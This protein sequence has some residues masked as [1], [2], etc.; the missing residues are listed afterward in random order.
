[1]KILY[2]QT[3][4]SV[5]INVIFNSQVSMK[6]SKIK[7]IKAGHKNCTSTNYY[8]NKIK[9]DDSMPNKQPLAIGIRMYHGSIMNHTDTSFK[10]LESCHKTKKIL[11]EF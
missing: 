11:Y 2:L 7:Y 6:K 8:G 5:G 3:I 9:C 1:M 10:D 4:T